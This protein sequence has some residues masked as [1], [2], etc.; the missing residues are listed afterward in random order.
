MLTGDEEEKT[1]E[2]PLQD[3]EM[4]QTGTLVV[5]SQFVVVP[6]DAAPNPNLNRNCTLKVTIESASFLK[7]ADTIGK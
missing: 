2:I 5:L 6:P 7:D 3:K 1:H 4:K